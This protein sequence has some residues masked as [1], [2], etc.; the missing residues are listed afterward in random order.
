MKQTELESFFNSLTTQDDQ[1]ID[2]R[3]N[4]QSV[5]WFK[6]GSE[7]YAIKVEDVQTVLDEFAVTPV[8]NT[9]RFVQGVINLRGNI[10]PIIDL[11]EM[12]QLPDV[13]SAK[14]RVIVLEVRELAML[15]V[16]ILVDDVRE[17]LDMDFAELQTQLPSLSGL[18][19]EYVMGVYRTEHH[20]IIL[21]DTVKIIQIAQ[22][23]ISKYS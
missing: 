15:K 12:F 13:N 3:F 11:R 10:I 8:P 20:V 1:Q 14:Q 23:M 22:E 5:L 9:P 2:M 6:L 18:G 4:L 19:I 21:A 7:E 17:V 16:G